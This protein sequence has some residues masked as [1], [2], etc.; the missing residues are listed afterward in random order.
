MN[1]LLINRELSLKVNRDIWSA[2]EYF[3]IGE[4]ITI[5]TK[6]NEVLTGLLK[7]I[8]VDNIIIECHN[9]DTI[10]YFKDIKN[11]ADTEWLCDTDIREL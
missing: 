6:C 9:K 5:L 3:W 1:K 8:N 7:D 11:I 2:N 10:I 4:D